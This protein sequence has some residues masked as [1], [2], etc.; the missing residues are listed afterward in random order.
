MARDC[1]KGM[2]VCLLR[3]TGSRMATDSCINHFEPSPRDLTQRKYLRRQR[4]SRHSTCL[5][6]ARPK[7]VITEMDHATLNGGAAEWLIDLL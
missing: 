6:S 4:L 2:P 1:R 7:L 3:T 5:G